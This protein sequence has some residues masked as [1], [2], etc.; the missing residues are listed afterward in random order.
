MSNSQVM[1]VSPCWSLQER[2]G[3]IHVQ[4]GG[5]ELSQ[6]MMCDLERETSPLLCRLRMNLRDQDHSNIFLQDYRCVVT[7]IRQEDVG[8]DTHDK[9]YSLPCVCGSSCHMPRKEEGSAHKRS[10]P[11]TPAPQ[12]AIGSADERAKAD[13]EAQRVERSQAKLKALQNATDSAKAPMRTQDTASDKSTRQ[14]TAKLT[15]KPAGSTQA[16]SSGAGD[17]P[18]PKEKAAVRKRPAQSEDES[19]ALPPTPVGS[20]TSQPATTDPQQ[21]IQPTEESQ[22]LPVE[23]QQGNVPIEGA[24]PSQPEE[25]TIPE[26]SGV[27]RR[28]V[29]KGSAAIAE[30][31][32][33]GDLRSD[34]AP[35][36][37]I[38]TPKAKSPPKPKAVPPKQSAFKDQQW[39]DFPDDPPESFNTVIPDTVPMAK[40]EPTSAPG[41]LNPKAAAVAVSRQGSSASGKFLLQVN[42]TNEWPVK[43][44][45]V[46]LPM[47]KKRDAFL[48]Q[49]LN[50]KVVIAHCPTGSG[51]S[52]ILPALAAM[53]LHT[54]AGRV[55][56]T[57]IRRVTTQFVCRDT[58]IIWG[59]DRNSPVVGFKHGTEK[60]EKWDENETK[61]LFLTEG[62]IMRQV[63]SHDEQ[64]YPDSILPG[65]KLL[66]LDEVHSGSTDVELILARILPRISQVPNFRWVLMS[67]TLN[68]DTFV[69]RVTSSGVDKTDVGIFLMEERTNPLALHCLPPDLLRNRD[70]IELAL[71]MVIKIHHEYRDGYQ[72]S[73]E[74]KQGPLEGQ[75]TFQIKSSLP[76]IL[77]KRE[78]TL[79]VKNLQDC[80][81]RLGAQAID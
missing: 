46:K 26:T 40:S 43:E 35:A 62:I 48:S 8:V 2:P 31:G 5:Q 69:N 11:Q 73:I 70:N 59:I 78:K 67:A 76:I 74:S 33:L 44:P 58:K 64:K 71:R 23:P 72:G 51:K 61:V 79:D 32:S 39:S 65:C 30:Q 38:E 55:C 7:V 37:S 68:I 21:A 24:Q 22:A 19:G 34:G 6:H 47:W 77:Y 49:F 80:A 42:E 4:E 16:S 41:S 45:K 53:H 57:Q 10:K 36:S 66:L 75:N 18:I 50:K 27:K 25:S 3:Q 15:D 1:S 56:C 12:G 20:E 13:K 52:T 17:T 63:M 29:R 14:K 60:S 81:S 28:M 9:C 54:K